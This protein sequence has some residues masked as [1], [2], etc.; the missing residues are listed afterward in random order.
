MKKKE[1]KK[2]IAIVLV[3]SII[4]SMMPVFPVSAEVFHNVVTRPADNPNEEKHTKPRLPGETTA[5][6][7][8]PLQGYTLLSDGTYKLMYDNNTEETITV[9]DT[10]NRKDVTAIGDNAY[11]GN[12]TVK[13]ITVPRKITSVGSFAFSG[14]TALQT[15]V[16]QNAATEIG[17]GAF[18]GCGNVTIK[19]PGHSAA[20][21]YAIVNNIPYQIFDINNARIYINDYGYGV[22]WVDIWASDGVKLEEDVDYTFTYTVDWDKM[23]SFLKIEGIGQYSGSYSETGELKAKYDIKYQ[24]IDLEQSSYV[25]DGTAKKP[26]VTV[27]TYC[28]NEGDLVP[29]NIPDNT[30]FSFG[31]LTQSSPVG[32]G[33]YR[34]LTEG[35]DYT[36]EY[37]N[38]INAGT[39]SAIVT[40]KRLYMGTVVKNFTIANTSLS[41]ASVTLSAN[42][43]TYDG[44]EKKPDVTVK[45]GSI[46]LSEDIDYFLRYSNNVFAGTAS[47]VVEGKGSYAETVTKNFTISKRNISTLD[48][49]LSESTFTYDGMAKTPDLILSTG[50]FTL[51]NG[52]NYTLSYANNVAAGTATVTATGKGNFTGSVSRNFTIQQNIRSISDCTITLSSESFTYDGTY[53]QPSVTVKYGSTVL[54]SSDYSVS[55]AQNK[56]AGTASVTVTGK[57]NYTGSAV[58]KFTINPKAL[59]PEML[60]NN[61]GTRIYDG[62]PKYPDFTVTDNG[63]KLTNHTDYEISYSNHI[64]AGIAKAIITGTGNY[65]DSLSLEYT[66]S[67]YVFSENS[68]IMLIPTKFE[69]DGNPKEPIVT[70]RVLSRDLEQGK[71]YTV[72]YSNN[73]QVGTGYAVVQGIGNY[74]GSVSKPFTITGKQISNSINVALSATSYTYDGTNHKP[75][76]TVTYKANENA[77]TVTLRSGT[78]YDVTY[79]ADCK[80]AGK[81]NVTVRCKNNYS[82]TKT[83][84]YTIEKR[85]ISTTQITLSQTA[86]TYDGTEKKPAVTVKLGSATLKE[87]TDYNVSYRDNVKVGTAQ[88]IVKGINNFYDEKIMEFMISKEITP[89]TWGVDNWSFNSS[90]DNFTNQ[91]YINGFIRE[92][93]KEYYNISEDEIKD[94]EIWMEWKNKPTSEDGGGGWCGSCYGMTTTEMLVKYGILDLSYFGLNRITNKNTVLKRTSGQDVISLINCFQVTQT[95]ATVNSVIRKQAYQRKTSQDK[96][97]SALESYLNNGNRMLNLFFKIFIEYTDDCM[98]DGKSHSK[99]TYGYLGDSSILA[100]GIETLKTKYHSD[101]TGLD[102]DKRILVADPNSLSSNTL[103]DEYCIYYRS[104]DYSWI[105]PNWCEK[106]DNNRKKVC[107]WINSASSDIMTGEIYGLYDYWNGVNAE[108]V[109]NSES[110]NHFI[111]GLEISNSNGENAEVDIVEEGSSN[112]AYVGSDE[113]DKGIRKYNASLCTDLNNHNTENFALWNPSS[114]YSALYQSTAVINLHMD[115]ED[116]AY[117]ATLSNGKYSNFSP[118]GYINIEGENTNYNISMVTNEEVC[119]TDWNQLTVQGD[120]V[121]QASLQKTEGGYIL[122][123]D[124]LSNVTVGARNEEVNISCE[125]S[126]KNQSAYIYEI[127]EYTIGIKTDNDGDGSFE[128]DLTTNVAKIGDVNGDGKV[129][130][131]DVTSIQRQVAEVADFSD[132]QRALADV[133]NDGVVNITDA[134]HLQLFIAEFDVTL[135]KPT[136]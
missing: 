17:T 96:Y 135:G 75:T 74:T 77:S 99:G 81:H 46:T 101:E 6:T 124:N 116:V 84:A 44:T 66:I 103:N 35:E 86:Y 98:I 89:F 97:I 20:E 47:V 113:T 58:K 128:T 14:C 27:Y 125:F 111:A 127:N 56:N 50:S 78:D 110:I 130:I 71:D 9:L 105:K 28:Q 37:V 51:V 52:K 118:S 133:N 107:Y 55:Y 76:V 5:P 3:I 115:F 40:G 134:T 42:S 41:A 70:A 24:T 33:Y 53:K 61:T 69:Y 32:D 18:E 45:L 21:N 126:T 122:K 30:N 62:S 95:Y 117:Y 57:G 49:R 29:D 136:T 119:V 100:Y 1:N 80:T 2:R 109:V 82:G 65:T 31:F 131:R 34:Y 92:K 16:I 123:A 22:A 68:S 4:L 13:Q 114:S 106:I 73:T 43:F 120:R 19:C 60:T 8:A 23:T 79:D 90:E 39:A 112:M 72:S 67:P 36:V 132:K 88:A 63:N 108:S 102:Y 104:S 48:A 94:M 93:F 121:N 11:T 59:T 26:K 87:G 15:V 64:N 85:H 83:V 129:N 25:Y 12:T 10:Y 54:T 38:N 7:E 91:Y